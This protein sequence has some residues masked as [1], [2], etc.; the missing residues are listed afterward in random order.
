MNQITVEAN[1]IEIENRALQTVATKQLEDS[2]SELN[3]SQLALIGGGSGAILL[4]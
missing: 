1:T 2:I 4:D 3:Y